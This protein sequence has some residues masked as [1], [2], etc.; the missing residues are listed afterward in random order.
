MSAWRKH[1]RTLRYAAADGGWAIAALLGAAAALAAWAVIRLHVEYDGP[2]PMSMREYEE[3]LL[4]D[5]WPNEMSDWEADMQSA[6]QALM[7]A[8]EQRT[9]MIME[10]QMGAQ[11][12]GPRMWVDEMAEWEEWESDARGAAEGA[13][14]REP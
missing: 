9:R 3:R 14:D 13:E 4:R 7:T 6:E 5:S 11:M 8:Q 2:N 1:L 12:K 10:A